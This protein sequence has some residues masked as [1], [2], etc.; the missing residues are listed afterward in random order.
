MACGLPARTFDLSD[1]KFDDQV[2]S[3]SQALDWIKRAARSSNVLNC[4][5]RDSVLARHRA[6]H[7]DAAIADEFRLRIELVQRWIDEE[8]KKPPQYGLP[9]LEMLKR[10]YLEYCSGCG[11]DSRI[12][13]SDQSMGRAQISCWVPH[14][15]IYQ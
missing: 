12:R 6:G 1:S 10:A 2:D 8:Q 11:K 9:V 4:N 14:S 5:W 15:M 7:A 13:C 3:T